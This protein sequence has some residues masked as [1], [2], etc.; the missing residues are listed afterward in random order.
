MAKVV[1]GYPLFFEAMNSSGLGVAG[2]NFEGNACYNEK[3]EDKINVPSYEL[4]SFLLGRCETVKEART[5]LSSVNI[6]KEAFSEKLPP[7]PLHFLVSDEIESITVE[8]TRE[9]LKIYEN[10]VGVLTNNP[11][12]P[13][14]LTRLCDFL[15]VTAESP[16]NRF[17]KNL[18]LTPYSFGMGGIGLPGDLS[19]SSR[20]IRACFFKE[21]SS[22]DT[23]SQFFRILSSTSQIKGSVKIGDK[24]EYSVYTS[25]FD[26]REK[27]Y[28][29]KKYEWLDRVECYAFN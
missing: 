10:P 7:S 19:S 14:H 13:Y 26:R 18:V 24:T 23:I 12:F 3:R 2:L 6:T 27:K 5:L 17:S 20:F 25:A 16:T 8:P 15:G 4:I 21:N 29:F 28:Y 22:E 1:D 11:E 9:G